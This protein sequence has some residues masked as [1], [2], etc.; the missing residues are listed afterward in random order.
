MAADVKVIRI[1][2]MVKCGEDIMEFECP[3]TAEKQRSRLVLR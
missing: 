1:E 3:E 2:E